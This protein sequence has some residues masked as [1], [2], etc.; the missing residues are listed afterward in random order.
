[1]RERLTRKILRAV[2]AQFSSFPE[3]LL[4]LVDNAFDEF[5]GVYGGRHLDIDIV[6]TKGSITVENLG[7]KGMGA[8]ELS[9]WLNWGEPHKRDA[10]GEYGQGGKAAMGYLGSS[11]VVQT[12]RWDKPWIWTI[13]ESNWDDVSSELKLYEAK[14]KHDE[15]KKHAGLGYCKFEVRKLK[16]HRQDINR[17]KMELSNIYR[18]YL[19]EG[20]ASITVNYEPLTPLQLPIYEGYKVQEFKEKTALGFNILGWIGRIKR[21]TRVRGGVKITGGMRLLRKGRL[22]YDGEYFGHPDFRWKASLGALIG[23]VEMGRVQVLPN[24]TGF[25]TDSPDWI[26]VRDLMHSILKPHIDELLSQKEEETVS[27]EERKRVTEARELMIEAF[28]RLSKYRDMAGR[29]AEERGRESPEKQS[30]AEEAKA[31]E[32]LLEKYKLPKEERKPRTPPPVDAVGKL[33]RL[34]KMPEWEIKI[35]P[36]E[37]RSEWG[38]REG[39]RCL[40]INKKYCLYAERDGDVMYLLETAALQ[41]A[42][43]EGDE[44]LSLEE[45]LD[46]VSL[47]MRACCEAYSSA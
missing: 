8:K 46:E 6:V 15:N 30:E 16:K 45:Y 19:K 17:I 23:E 13:K 39:R 40:L 47:I 7:G 4:E 36:L 34:G 26:A 43:P 18:T 12:K 38:E 25:D 21:D 20:K 37:I 22:I 3:A 14:A 9:D 31:Q 1:M 42:K 10:I 2:M 35:L 44:K 29:L 32:E 28:K 5:D 41:L 33:Q 11:W 27:R 24:K